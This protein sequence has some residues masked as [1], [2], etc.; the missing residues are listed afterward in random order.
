MKTIIIDDD[1]KAVKMLAEKLKPYEGLQLVGK[2]LTGEKGIALLKNAKPDVVFLD[3]ELP[4]MSGIYFLEQ[5]NAVSN[6]QCRIVMYTGYEDYMLSSFRNKAFDFLLKP[7]DDNEL[8]Q[9]VQ[10]LYT[11]CGKGK[12]QI[13]ELRNVKQQDVEKLLLY[14]NSIDFRL[15]HLRDIGLFQYNHDLRVWE[16]VVAG[17]KEP[18]RLKRNANNVSLLAIDQRFI[19]VSQRY[20]ININ[21]LLEVIDN[22]CHLYPPFNN[23]NYVN[24]GRLYRKNLTDKFFTL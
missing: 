17:R 13:N 21:Y 20:I 15:V 8:G 18:I 9:V 1:P 10:R 14:T 11:S 16:V 6:G 23:I 5:M 7:I 3:V 19:Q 24:V 2:A 4:D 22:T 12:Q